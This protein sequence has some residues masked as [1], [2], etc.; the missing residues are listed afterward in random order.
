[1]INHTLI[2]PCFQLIDFHSNGLCFYI[3]KNLSDNSIGQVD[4]I[5]LFLIDR[6]E[7]MFKF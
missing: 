2:G 3:E 5:R 6:E 7:S 1:M 4:R